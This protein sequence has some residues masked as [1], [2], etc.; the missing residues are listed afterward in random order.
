M[1]V[2]FGAYMPPDP[3]LIAF[4]DLFNT[5]GSRTTLKT[6]DTVLYGYVC[7]S[8][9]VRKARVHLRD[10]Y[11]RLIADTDCCGRGSA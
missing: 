2:I 1:I 7:H 11:H 5:I 10:E 8:G 9:G 3:V 4:N 6:A